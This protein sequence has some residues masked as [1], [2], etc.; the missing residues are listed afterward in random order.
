MSSGKMSLM[1]FFNINDQLAII[2]EKTVKWE[3]NQKPVKNINI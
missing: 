3:L 2:K 1:S